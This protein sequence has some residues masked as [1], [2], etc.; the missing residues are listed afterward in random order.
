MFSDE[1]KIDMNFVCPRG[2][3]KML[4]QRA[5]SVYWKK[6][7]AKHPYEELKE[8]V[9]LGT[10]SSS[11]AKESEGGKDRKASQCGQE[12]LG[13]R[14]DTRETDRHW[15][16]RCQ[17]MSRL[18]DGGRHREAQALPL[19]GMARSKAGYSGMLQEVIAKGENVK[20]RMEMAKR[21]GRAPSQ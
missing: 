6:W 5:R 14:L 3:K 2:V 13:R 1:I 15:L 16:V 7:A 9:W 11:L 17:P 8:G 20:E 12:D 18:P 21:Y 10:S 19:S 4:V